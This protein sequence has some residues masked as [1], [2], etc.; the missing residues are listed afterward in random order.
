M[1]D[2]KPR[3]VSVKDENGYLLADSQ[4][5]FS[6]WKNYIVVYFHPGI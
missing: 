4:N 6:R 2:Y 3:T 1:E 5:I